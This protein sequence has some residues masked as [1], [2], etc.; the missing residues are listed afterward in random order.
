[1]LADMNTTAPSA[2]R[3]LRPVSPRQLEWLT[4]EVRSWE[5]EGLVDEQQAASILGSYRAGRRFGLGRLML[6]LG[7]AFIGVGLIW[8]VA[9]NLDQFPP[10]ARWLVVTAIWLGLVA[11]AHLLSE[12]RRRHRLP[13]SSPVVGAVRGGAALAFGAVIF[14]AAQSLQVPAY[15]P[16]L[17]GFWGAGALLYAYAVRAMAPLTVGVTASLVWFVWQVLAAAESGLG[18]V[19]A[20]LVGGVIAAAVSVLHRRFEPAGFAV[21]W[22]EVGALL[23]LV[24]LFVAAVPDVDG[25][26]FRMTATLL[27]AVLVAVALA[28]L[29]LALG[30][31]V[32]RLLPLGALAVASVGTGLVAWETDRVTGGSIGAGDWLQAALSVAAYVLVAG[33]VAA[34][35]I[36]RDSPRLTWLALAALVVFTTFQSFAVFSQVITG[37]WLFV[38]LGLVFVG[39]G[40]VF[41]R[42]RRELESTL[43]GE[44][45]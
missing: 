18:V 44:L 16:A 37:A 2:P 35:G 11:G 34:L 7:S 32:T 40:L 6:Y 22:R 28:A 38:V 24:G 42:A 17:V 36:L 25:G 45:S 12:R 29:A 30:R 15:E 10:L 26:D 43:E 13:D 9:S 39:S 33:A 3:S 8:L 20:F 1:M 23:V 27:V 21:V 19:L 5:A 4:D 31:D 14:Q 41:D